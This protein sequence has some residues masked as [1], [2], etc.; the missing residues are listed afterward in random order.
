MKLSDNILIV[1]VSIISLLEL[2]FILFSDSNGKKYFNRYVGLSF[3]LF[4]IL[5]LFIVIFFGNADS[6]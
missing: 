4:V 6:K 1:I 5:I 3:I 2:F